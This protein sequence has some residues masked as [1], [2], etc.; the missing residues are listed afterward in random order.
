VL[1]G[2]AAG[3]NWRIRQWS[4]RAEIVNITASI[5]PSVAAILRCGAAENL[6]QR[7][8]SGTLPQCYLTQPLRSVNWSRSVHYRLCS[9]KYWIGNFYQ[10]GRFR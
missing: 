9:G 3:Q 2:V 6:K 7:L 8:P 10:C 1:C 4:N 5:P